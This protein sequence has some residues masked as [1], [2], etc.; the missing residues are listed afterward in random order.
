ML[1][2]SNFS[3]KYK[4]SNVM[5][6]IDLVKIFLR[7]LS[8]ESSFNFSHMQ[9]VGF[10][11]SLIPLMKRL[12]GERK[13]IAP[14]LQRHVQLFNTHPYMT[15]AIIGSVARLEEGC[16]GDDCPEA[17]LLK[18]S[19]MSP[20]AAMGDPFFWG[21]LRPLT[22]IVGVIMALKGLIVAPIVSIVLYN[23]IHLWVRV[24]GFIEGYRDGRGAI[25]FLK[26]LNMPDMSRNIRWA[27]LFLLA[28]LAIIITM[29]QSFPGVES[30]GVWRS[31]AVL[32]VI[33]VFSWLMEKGLSPLILLY[34][35]TVLC[36]GVA[37]I[38]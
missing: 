35:S 24:K 2:K 7:S 4:E 27:S 30:F 18:E 36:A 22:L 34:G 38:Q 20:Y 25:D 13:S 8:I 1:E 6:T 10:A 16:S 9:N 3:E 32:V 14:I 28:L 21:A 11:Y 26:T 19:V 29:L 15:G 23:S 17:V 37:V 33:L 5:R 31:V 12:G